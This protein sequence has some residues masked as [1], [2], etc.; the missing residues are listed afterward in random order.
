MSNLNIE[1]LTGLK[2]LVNTTQERIKVEKMR[3]EEN[4]HLKVK[5]G[6]GITVVNY[7]LRLWLTDSN[8]VSK[9]SWIFVD[10]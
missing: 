5:E 4:E 1:A 9:A 6:K 3:D 8:D 10:R 2:T 7:R